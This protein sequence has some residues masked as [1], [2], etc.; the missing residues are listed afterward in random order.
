MR[1]MAGAVL[2]GLML[3]GCSGGGHDLPT[4]AEDGGI[5]VTSSAFDEGD[6]IPVRFT[7]DGA[8]EAPPVSWSGASGRGSIVV[9]MTDL[10]ANRFVHWLVYNLGGSSGSVGGTSTRGEDGQNDFGETGYSGPCPPGGPS[11]RYVITVYELEIVP[12]PMVPDESVD[13]I[14]SGAPIDRGSLTGT[15]ARK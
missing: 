4:G 7:C 9:L 2:A 13:Q 6:P 8:N 1:R 5:T 3:A 10:D 15:Y 11:H 14:L 12:S